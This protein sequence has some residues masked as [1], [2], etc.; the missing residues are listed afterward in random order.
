VTMNQARDRTRS[1]FERRQR[2][3]AGMKHRLSHAAPCSSSSS[4]SY[5]RPLPASLRRGPPSKDGVR[6]DGSRRRPGVPGERNRALREYVAG[7]WCALPG[8]H[9][10]GFRVDGTPRAPS[11]SRSRPARRERSSTTRTSGGTAVGSDG[12][13]PQP[14]PSGPAS[15]PPRSRQKRGRSSE[16]P[17]FVL[18][19][20]TPSRAQDSPPFQSVCTVKLTVAGEPEATRVRPLVT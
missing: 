2:K 11:P 16:R 10:V 7:G 18:A 19:R 4:L 9:V 5:P 1:P 12:K 17:R 15:H 6:P 3:E 13:P 8:H 14:S 20:D